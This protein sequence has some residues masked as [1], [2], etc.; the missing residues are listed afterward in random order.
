MPGIT[1]RIDSHL[2]KYGELPEAE[3][4]LFMIEDQNELKKRIV[5]EAVIITDSWVKENLIK[6]L[7]LRNKIYSVVNEDIKEA[8]KILEQIPNNT[9][10]IVGFGGGRPSDIAKYVARTL[11]CTL[12]AVPT[13][14]SN[15]GISSGVS[16]LLVKNKK[17]TVKTK[18]PD[19]VLVY[20]KFW[21][22]VPPS[23]IHAGTCDILGKITSLQDVSLSIK[24]GEKVDPI[25]TG[26]GLKCLSTILISK[27]GDLE[28]LGKSLILSGESMKISSRVASGSEHEVEKL[29]TKNGI[30]G[31]HGQLVGLGTLIS[32]K[33]YQ[34][35]FKKFS[36]L[37]FNSSDLFDNTVSIFRRFGVLEFV[38]EPLG[39]ERKK[40]V[41][42][43]KQV[44]KVR[45]ERHTLWN[46]V[47]S[48]KVDWKNI[49]L[50]IL[51]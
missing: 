50:K 24:N 18:R 51:E 11:N 46:E 12:I 28:A 49:V 33:V 48:E 31:S 20:K 1:E 38:L 26:F 8:E 44:S 5:E 21:Q 19:K 29:L 41:N 9:R 43:L 13:A 40:I 17:T 22:N 23:F 37:F 39:K 32:A 25:S 15:D 2:K 30:R 34:E 27:P 36:G 42:L 35:N 6:P 14:P 47:D 10:I 4:S 16:A 3:V 45:P 7:Q